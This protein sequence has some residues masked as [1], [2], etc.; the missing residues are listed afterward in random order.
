MCEAL[1]EAIDLANLNTKHMAE[2]IDA[3]LVPCSFK[4]QFLRMADTRG[5]RFDDETIRQM[6]EIGRTESDICL[7]LLEGKDAGL[8][9]VYVL[10][11]ELDDDKQRAGAITFIQ[12]NSKKKTITEKDMWKAITSVIKGG[13]GLFDE[14]SNKTP[15]Q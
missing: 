12:E 1:K 9:T 10:A 5:F 8:V 14:R 7:M 15:Q 4:G 13:R 2:R 6:E 11:T 3:L